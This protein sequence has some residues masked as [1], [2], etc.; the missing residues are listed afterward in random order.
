[1]VPGDLCVSTEGNTIPG[2]VTVHSCSLL[3]MPAR[4]LPTRSPGGLKAGILTSAAPAGGIE[5]IRACS[6]TR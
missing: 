2:D 1:M 5:P 4:G 6:Q 3:Q